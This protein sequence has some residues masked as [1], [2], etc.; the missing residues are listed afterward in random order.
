MEGQWR[1]LG[2]VIVEQRVG[3][4]GNVL[5]GLS[6]QAAA[7]FGPLLVKHAVDTGIRGHD[8]R[9]LALS[10]GGLVALGALEDLRSSSI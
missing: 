9:A 5:A 8:R 7:V 3:V 6:W 10:V 2:R 1:Y 4:L